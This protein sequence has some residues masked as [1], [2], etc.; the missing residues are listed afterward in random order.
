MDDLDRLPRVKQ[1]LWFHGGVTSCHVC[2]VRH[3]MLYGSHDADDPPELAL[4]RAVECFYVRYDLPQ[5][6]RQAAA[7]HD[8]GAALSLRE[9]VFLAERRLGRAISWND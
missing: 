3:D 4:D 7:W 1:G 6:P 5:V 8:G 9:A 2:I